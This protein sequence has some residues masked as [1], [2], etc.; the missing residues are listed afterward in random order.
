MTTTD[1]DRV[2]LEIERRLKLAEFMA[3]NTVYR[4]RV[5][6][7]PAFATSADAVA[8]ERGFEQFPIEPWGLPGSPRMQGYRD[9]ED[10]H[11]RG[12][13]GCVERRVAS[14]LGELS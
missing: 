9:A 14:A 7:K 6:R 2:D 12:L 3:R 5:G 11:L 10:E 1:Q 4:A 13:T 8:Y